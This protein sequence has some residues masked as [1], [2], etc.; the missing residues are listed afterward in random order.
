MTNKS[1]AIPKN[2]R[3][4][5]DRITSSSNGNNLFRWN[6]TS[7]RRNLSNVDKRRILV[8]R[9]IAGDKRPSKSRSELSQD[10]FFDSVNLVT[11]F[12][13]CSFGK[14]L[15]VPAVTWSGDDPNILGG[16]Y[17]VKVSWSN[18]QDILERRVINK[19]NNKFDKADLPS[20]AGSPV[21][22]KFD[23]VM[24]CFPPGVADSSG[25][26]TWAGYAYLNGWLSV[27]NDNY[28]SRPSVQVSV[29]LI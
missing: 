4:S 26:T 27:Y 1:I 6:E 15:F 29:S 2:A 23:H 8:V 18:N 7:S 20:L 13:D 19:L 24:F 3:C 12:R 11:Q 25:K 16:V 9:V 22:D 28:C 14:Q 21:G 17:Q 5:L 10:I